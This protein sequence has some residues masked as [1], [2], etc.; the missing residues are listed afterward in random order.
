MR[1]R[2]SGPC[3]QQHSCC[4]DAS[5]HLVSPHHT[6]R[7]VLCPL[8]DGPD[9]CRM[10]VSKQPSMVPSL[11]AGFSWM[12]LQSPPSLLLSLQA[13]HSARRGGKMLPSR[14]AACAASQRG[15]L[16]RGA[17]AL[18]LPRP[19]AHSRVGLWHGSRCSALPSRTA[20]P[21][22]P[23]VLL[24]R[25][26]VVACGTAVSEA[27]LMEALDQAKSRVEETIRIRAA[28]EAEVGLGGGAGVEGWRQR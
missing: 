16:Q 24:R 9:L 11:A 10:A 2:T 26:L 19:V 13:P 1:A 6:F 14:S 12:S 8:W 27:P 21:S 18:P 20:G 28:L 7:C 5:S 17:A 23:F 3:V 4:P 15:L 25:P 22:P